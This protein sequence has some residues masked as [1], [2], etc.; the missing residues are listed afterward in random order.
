MDRLKLAL[1]VPL[2]QAVCV[3]G[4]L[5][6]GAKASASITSTVVGVSHPVTGSVTVAHTEVGT[7]KLKSAGFVIGIVAA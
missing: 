6:V 1:P 5:A 3:P 2:S 7:L 4:L